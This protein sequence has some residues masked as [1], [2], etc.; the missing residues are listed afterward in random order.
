MSHTAAGTSECR[1]T[2]PT[3]PQLRTDL[4]TGTVA[5]KILAYLEQQIPEL[6]H[7]RSALPTSPPDPFG[8]F[9]AA[10]P[11][12]QSTPLQV[13]AHS[14]QSVPPFQHLAPSS[15]AAHPLLLEHALLQQQGAVAGAPGA[16]VYQQLRVQPVPNSGA[17][18]QQQ[19][20][21]GVGSVHSQLLLGAQFHQPP[22]FQQAPVFQQ[23]V[24][25][26]VNQNLEQ[27]MD[28]FLSQTHASQDSTQVNNNNVSLENLLTASVKLR[29]YRAIDFASLSS[30]NYISQ[31]K[32]S[33]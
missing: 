32:P 16:P 4:E 11:P 18:Q 25:P 12:Q 13:S 30:F 28:Q 17:C 23:H 6:A 10:P 3:V 5:K 2:G 8:P 22:A 15:D 9:Q 1:Y 24:T 26:P 33:N 31:L 20:L 19:L 29:Q 14:L 27:V 21:P 7:N